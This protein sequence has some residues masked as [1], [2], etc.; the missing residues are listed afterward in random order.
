MNPSKLLSAAV[1]SFAALASNSTF[2]A[3]VSCNDG[4]GPGL[5]E[6]TIS[7]GKVGG[8][9]YTL[10]GNFNANG[11]GNGVTS[12]A[13]IFGAGFGAVQIDRDQQSDASGNTYE[14]WLTGY[15]SA[16]SGNWTVAED[17]W[18]KYQRLFLGFHF[19][20]GGDTAQDNPDSFI[21]ELAR[22]D[23]AGTWALTGPA[24]IQF[25]GLSHINLIGADLCTADPKICDGGGGG[26]GGG[27]SVP[28]PGSL[29]L[30]GLALAAAYGIRRRQRS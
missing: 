15:S 10:N 24:G 13:T 1:L 2:A 4:A 11:N 20:G 21:V 25:N 19:G 30:A 23:N 18:N 29:A 12:Y 7:P 28:E 3:A 14:S 16:T 27:G 26:G 8:F 6:L 17:A 5:R 22:S 9:C